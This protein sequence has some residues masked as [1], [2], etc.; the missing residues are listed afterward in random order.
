MNESRADARIFGPTEVTIQYFDYI[1]TEQ[2]ATSRPTV[3]ET[4]QP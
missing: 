3:G 1:T 4:G 2:K